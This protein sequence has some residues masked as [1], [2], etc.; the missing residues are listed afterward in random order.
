M[1][2]RPMALVC[3]VAVL[4][5]CTENAPQPIVEKTESAEAPV[6]AVKTTTEV[7]PSTPE[8]LSDSTPEPTPDA[9]SYAV[10]E[11]PE[12]LE[13]VQA[14][15]VESG[16]LKANTNHVPVIAAKPVEVRG[17]GGL[18][19]TGTGRG[20][21]GSAGLGG[22]GSVGSGMGYG[23]GSSGGSFR[24]Q[25]MRGVVVGDFA[26]NTESYKNYGTND[27]TN[28]SKDRFSTF[29]ADVDTASYTIARRKLSDGMLPPVDSVRVE[30][31]VNYFSYDYGRAK[32]GPFA[33]DVEAAPSPFSGD[34]AM[35][36]LRV[37][38]QTDKLMKSERKPIHL[39]FLVDVSGSMGG[40]H[41]LDLAKRSLVHLVENLQAQDTVAIT[42]YAG[43]T[44]VILE[45]TSATERSKIIEKIE[46]LNTGGGTAM[47]DGLELAYRQAAK[48]LQPGHV[49]RVIVLSDGDANIGRTSHEE[50]LER[51]GGYVQ[52]GVTLSTIGFGMG[53]YKD[54][55]MEQLANKGNGNYAYI[56]DFKE[57]R[58]VFGEQLDGTLQVVAKDVKFQVEFDPEMV[59][60]YRLI[61]Y[62]NRDI[63]DKDF[64][65]DKVDAGEVG[66]GH[67][68]TALFEV[69]LKQSEAGSFA[70]VRIRHKAPEAETATEQ[71]FPIAVSKIHT[72][73]G[74][75]SKDFQF[76]VAVAGFAE[77]LRG[78]KHAKNLS[79]DLIL[80]VAESST[81]THKSRKEFVNLVKKARRL[82][83]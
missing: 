31:F 52:E 49:S 26:T 67:R 47:G 43:S 58:K 34:P 24:G 50:L 19:I 16:D 81:G 14:L 11:P 71:A 51:I 61:G 22:I 30:E 55:M 38:V 33:V 13:I 62:E 37:G 15:S 2:A 18:G 68:V 64:R 25:G 57:A 10:A 6:T 8:P 28:P 36:V 74:D 60:E 73:V 12:S 27:F 20:G 21:G 65:N 69:R 39:T 17:M 63:A 72:R 44:A 53:N 76:A 79:L 70:T 77:I 40:P 23:R 7:T 45:P 46:S 41:K 80:E 83:G 82:R 78:S 48:M 56:D 9:L 3:V 75:A 59:A 5:A 54:V 1:N 35:R 32:N 66:A 4:C 29:A 42:T